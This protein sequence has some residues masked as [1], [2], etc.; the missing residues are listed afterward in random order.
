MDERFDR[1]VESPVGPPDGS[2]GCGGPRVL[3]GVLVR[4]ASSNREMEARRAGVL[5]VPFRSGCSLFLRLLRFHHG[6]GRRPMGA[7]RKIEVFSA[8]C[9]VCQEAVALVKRLACPSCEV[10]VLDMNDAAVAGR[11][12]ELGIRSIPAVVIDGK[13]AG[14]CSGRG[15]DEATLRQAGLGQ[16][17]G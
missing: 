1:R 5:L 11:A 4:S 13:L 17:L 16:R 8:G 6:V 2:R 12:A 9:S 7:K 10:T 15:P 3:V 14:C